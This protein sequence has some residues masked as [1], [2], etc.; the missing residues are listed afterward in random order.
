MID[1]TRHIDYIIDKL[2]LAFDES[3]QNY[4]TLTI[5]SYGIVE[6]LRRIISQNTADRYI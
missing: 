4:V 5:W 6:K 2:R 1:I 3:K